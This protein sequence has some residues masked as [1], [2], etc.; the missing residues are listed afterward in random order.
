MSEP[1]PFLPPG[2]ATIDDF[3]R[4]DIRVGRIARGARL[5]RGAQA[6]LPAGHRLRT[7]R[8]HVGRR[9]S[10]P[11]T[12][13]DPAALVGRL[14]VC[15]VNFPPRR[16]AGFMSEVLVLGGLPAGWPDP[17]AGGRRG[18]LAR[19]IRSAE[20]GRRAMARRSAPCTILP[21]GMS[22]GG[23]GSPGWRA[24]VCRPGRPADAPETCRSPPAGRFDAASGSGSRVTSRP[25]GPGRR[26]GSQAARAD[27]ARSDDGYRWM[28]SRSGALPLVSCRSRCPRQLRD[29]AQGHRP[30]RGR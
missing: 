22:D 4:L 23:C 21:R 11:G 28:P 27:A 5:P 6:R 25:C 1:R 19:A 8:R 14:V 24:N 26:T 15:V 9:P 3:L 12:Y 16:I 17:A 2:S 30:R 29:L 13:P 10:C 18:C 7:G 20:R